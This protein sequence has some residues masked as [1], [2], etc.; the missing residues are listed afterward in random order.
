LLAVPRLGGFFFVSFFVV[1][2][3]GARKSA[4]IV[5][6]NLSKASVPRGIQVSY[7]PL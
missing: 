3:F 5:F 4:T 7:L 2:V 1:T 6:S